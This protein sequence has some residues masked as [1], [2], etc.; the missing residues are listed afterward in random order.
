MRSQ[1]A[2]LRQLLATPT[3]YSPQNFS[4]TSFVT[5][6]IDAVQCA[7]LSPICSRTCC[8]S[9]CRTAATL[10][11]SPLPHHDVNEL[12]NE[13]TNQQTNKH[14]GSQYFLA[15]VIVVIK[16]PTARHVCRYTSLPCEMLVGLFNTPGPSESWAR[17]R[18][19][20]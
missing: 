7:R 4:R 10:I 6:C 9:P 2:D 15:L 17:Q 5:A 14:D 12:L 1:A 16:H 18:Q 3:K 19:T 13:R 20:Y 11:A 8:A